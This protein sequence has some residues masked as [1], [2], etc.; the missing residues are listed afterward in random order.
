[1]AALPGHASEPGARIDRLHR[2]QTHRVGPYRRADQAVVIAPGHL[3]QFKRP[4]LADAALIGVGEAAAVQE[5][6]R[7]AGGIGATERTLGMC[8][9]GQAH[10]ADLSIAPRLANDP[11][12]AIETIQSIAEIFDELAFRA[13]AP[14][15]VLVDHR[16]A[17]ADEIACHLRPRSRLRIGER[18]LRSAGQ[19]AAIGRAFQQH[20]ERAVD[21]FTAAGRAV[22]VGGEAYAV[23]HRH[24]DRALEHHVVPIRGQ[25]RSRQRKQAERCAEPG[26]TPARDARLGWA[27]C[28]RAHPA[29]SLSPSSLSRHPAPP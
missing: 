6:R 25:R 20:G 13:I 9:I 3:F 7:H 12:A 16:I 14:A 1:M 22:Y 26:Q 17:A 24:H 2:G 21:R 5:H 15:A 23:A 10:R 11:G 27:G 19:M 8:R 18:N 4:T 28:D 29:R